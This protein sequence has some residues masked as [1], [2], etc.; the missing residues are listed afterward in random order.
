MKYISFIL[1]LIGG[2]ISFN[3]YA[4][5]YPTDAE[6][7]SRPVVTNIMVDWVVR[8]GTYFA[9]FQ[10]CVYKAVKFYSCPNEDNECNADWLPFMSYGSLAKPDDKPSGSSDNSDESDKI[11]NQSDGTSSGSPALQPVEIEKPSPVDTERPSPSEPE[12]PYPADAGVSQLLDLYNSCHSQAY[13][14]FFNAPDSVFN[15]VAQKCN[16]I[17]ERLSSVLIP[18][19]IGSFSDDGQSFLI[20]NS[21]N[22]VLLC[23]KTTDMERQQMI[24]NG[25]HPYFTPDAM[26]SVVEKIRYRDGTLDFNY[27]ND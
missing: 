23:H 13:D 7:Q 27:S 24:A 4:K 2:V 15:S 21:S 8:N 3:A 14:L 6:C 17:L 5:D 25:Y 22:S 20:K 16:A 10:G 1:L 9:E 12:K 19:E 26:G 18:D 11:P